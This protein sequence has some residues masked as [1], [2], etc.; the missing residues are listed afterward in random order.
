MLGIGGMG[1][2]YAAHD[3]RFSSMERL[4]AVK[5]MLASHRDGKNLT[6]IQDSFDREA[7]IL[8]SLSHPAIPKVYD[9]F[10][11][12]DHYFLVLELIDGKDLETILDEAA[13]PLPVDQVVDWAIQTCEVLTYLHSHKPK[14]IVFRDMKPSN[15]MLCKDGRIMLVDFGIAK[16]LQPAARGTMI[17]T[18]GYAPPEQYKG[19]ADPRVDIYALGATMHHLLTN[20]DPRLEPPFSFHQR[21]VAAANPDVS[22]ELSAVIEQSLAYE[23]HIRFRSA[24]SLRRALTAFQKGHRGTQP[25]SGVTAKGPHTRLAQSKP[26]SLR[27]QPVSAPAFAPIPTQ[28]SAITPLWTFACEEEVRSSPALS[29]GKL[30]IG[31]YDNNLYA[32]D[33]QT[34]KFLWKYAT[35]GG[36]A[37]TPCVEEDLI[38]V[39]SEDRILYAIYAKTGQIAWTFP[40]K[41][42]IRSSPRALGGYVFFGSDDHTIYAVNARK[43][44]LR[45]TFDTYKP[46]RSSAGFLEHF[47]I[48]GGED[49]FLYALDFST[50]KVQWKV[51]PGGPLVSSVAV[52]EKML[53]V[54]SMD[55][56][57]YALDARSGWPVWQYRTGDRI[58]SSPALS[59][60]RLYI[61]SVDGYLY[62]LD[63]RWGKL[64]WRTELGGQV[65]SS[66]AVANDQVYVAST[67]GSLFCLNSKNGKIVWSYATQGPVPSSPAVVDG[68]VYIGSIDHHVYALPA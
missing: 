14:P 40:T 23:P 19:V 12:S 35:E 21:P 17:G 54:G 57:I 59:G 45:W 31:C 1:A 3:L 4:C 64:V 51:R 63:A 50:G 44:H 15:I 52:G 24:E 41:G 39:G 34:G 62:C 53:Y 66:P 13:K 56:M 38:I 6:Q 22:P 55:W 37:S 5:E 49:G 26:A 33:A 16:Q 28:P 60:E 43:G 48:M 30:Y 25:S 65:T 46:I 47:V 2:V 36:I 7:N 9:Y 29:A 11:E 68:V 67:N 18:E 42:R 58:I 20:Q 32:I 10:H 27:H 61:G 8:A